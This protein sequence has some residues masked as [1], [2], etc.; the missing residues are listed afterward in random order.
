MLVIIAAC[1][2]WA[3]KDKVAHRLEQELEGAR[4]ELDDHKYCA[5]RLEAAERVWTAELDLVTRERD[6]LGE[7]LKASRIQVQSLQKPVP[8]DR[9]LALYSDLLEDWPQD[10]GTL[11][12]LNHTFISKSWAR[13]TASQISTFVEDGKEYL[14]DDKFVDTA[15]WRF[16]SACA[17]FVDWM[18]TESFPSDDNPE[19]QIVPERTGKRGG[20]DAFM[21]VRRRGEELATGVVDA[22]REFVRTGR[23]RSL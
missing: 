5:T 22:W 19:L 15:F 4:K 7:D 20:Y 2:A 10:S 23:A 18:G 11:Y 13:K 3:N 16:R 17:E 6:R 9:D 14:F 21:E 1:A 8:T 12:W